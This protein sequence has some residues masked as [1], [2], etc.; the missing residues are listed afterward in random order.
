MEQLPLE[1]MT[2]VLGRVAFQLTCVPAKVT[3]CVAMADIL[4]N[5]IRAAGGYAAV[6]KA[7]GVTRQTVYKW[8]DCVP[9]ERVPDLER[10]IGVP[11]HKLRP[12]FFSEPMAQ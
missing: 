7:L 4:D 2:H 9:L 5:A 3:V 11:R 6:A 10:A 8:K 1:I 12:D